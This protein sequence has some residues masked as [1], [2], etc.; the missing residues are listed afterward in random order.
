M[1]DKE[2][3]LINSKEE[4]DIFVRQLLN[5]GEEMYRAGGEISRI[6]DTLHRLAKEYGAVHVSVFA[7]TSSINVTVEF[8]GDYSITQNRRITKRESVDC[9]KMEMLN[10]LCRECAACPVSVE[11]LRD[12]VLEVMSTKRRDSLYYLG[13]IIAVMALTVFFG[14]NMLD[15]LVSAAGALVIIALQ[16]WIRPYFSSMLFFNVAVSLATGVLVNFLNQ[17]IPGIHVNQILIGDIMVLIPGIAITNSMRY[18]LSGDTVSSF[19]KLTDSLLQAF[20]IAGGFMIS[21]ILVPGVIMDAPERTGLLGVV[22]TLLSAVIGTFGFCLIF[23]IRART[24]LI[25][26][27][28]GLLSFGM[29]L[30]VE[31]MGGNVFLAAFVASMMIGVYGITFARIAK[32]P[33]TILFIPA[34]IPLIPGGYLYYSATALLSQ[35]WIAFRTNITCLILV[36]V[37]ISLGLA[38]VGEIEKFTGKIV[39]SG[40][41]RKG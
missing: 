32:V 34:C 38:T 31:N 8:E 17:I 9:T 19:E 15:S 29:Y 41:S 1:A 30:F 24:I 39:G 12:R 36:A 25:P 23:N 2:K 6:E 11:E 5:I 7:I 28:G 21:I 20:G 3:A 35:D 14:G 16:K 33:T 27:F 26:T 13:E 40:S 22:I 37:G 10:Q 4:A 18:I